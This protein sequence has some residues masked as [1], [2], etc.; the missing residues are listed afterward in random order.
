[1]YNVNMYNVYV[2]R[3][4]P[5]LPDIIIVIITIIPPEGSYLPRVKKN[6]YNYNYNIINR[7]RQTDRQ[8]HTQA[9][10]CLYV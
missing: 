2:Q 7:H 4:R 1:M 10:T 9:S 8:T 3:T 6:M 5:E